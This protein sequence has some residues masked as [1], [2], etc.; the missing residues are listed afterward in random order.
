MNPQEIPSTVEQLVAV[1]NY[2]Q[3]RVEALEARLVSRVRV[4]PESRACV[5]CGVE[6]VRG[7]DEY[8][9]NYRKRR[10]CSPECRSKLLTRK[11][12]V[13]VEPRECVVCGA[14]IPRDGL[15]PSAYAKRSTCSVKCRRLLMSDSQV[16]SWRR[17]RGEVD[18]LS[19]ARPKAPKTDVE[20]WTRATSAVRSFGGLPVTLEDVADVTGMGKD[21]AKRML[22]LLVSGGVLACR[23]VDGARVWF[24]PNALSEAA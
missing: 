21:R 16:A 19:D 10:T 4:E 15:R 8:P 5:V 20:A 14:V 24:D 7:A 6:F 11:H 3:D 22:D 13:E 18:V 1:V 12:R 23:K 2:L 17:R 9:S